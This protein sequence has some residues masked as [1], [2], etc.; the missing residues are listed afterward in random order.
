MAPLVVSNTSDDEP[1]ATFIPTYLGGA[2]EPEWDGAE[3][4]VFVLLEAFCGV[5]ER[6]D[7]VG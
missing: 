1:Y 5:A 6:E 3:G 4:L 7:A 2:T